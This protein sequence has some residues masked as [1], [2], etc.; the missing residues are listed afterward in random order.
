VIPPQELSRRLDGIHHGRPKIWQ[1][2]LWVTKTERC[3]KKRDLSK[4][5]RLLI[6]GDKFSKSNRDFSKYLNAWGPVER[7][8]QS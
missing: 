7:L 2:Y 5:D 8:N 1:V 6:A 3:C 4:D